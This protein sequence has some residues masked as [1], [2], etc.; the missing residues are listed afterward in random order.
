MN[1]VFDFAG[2]LFHWQ[3]PE[4]LSRLLPQRTPDEAAAR[5]LVD[6]IFQGYTGDWGDFDRGTVEPG[7]LAER[8]AQRTGLPVDDVRRV[9][10][11][12]PA[13]LTP[14]AGTVALLRELHAVTGESVFLFPGV[15]R[16]TTFISETTFGMALKHMGFRGRQVAHGFRSIAS[17]WLNESGGFHPDVIER[18]LAHEPANEVRSAYNRAEYLDER[19]RMMGVWAGHLGQFRPEPLRGETIG[20]EACAADACQHG[21]TGE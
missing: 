2:V 18:Q 16:S 7:P 10:D 21:S 3:P 12:V 9:I 20:A 4:L 6:D 17:T 14:I 15:R 8:I 11:G 5:R 19:R 1:V 13:E